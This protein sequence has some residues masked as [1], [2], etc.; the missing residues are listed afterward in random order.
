ML[1]LAPHRRRPSKCLAFLH[2]IPILAATLGAFSD[3]GVGTVTA[4]LGSP[5]GGSGVFTNSGGGSI[6]PY[7]GSSLSTVPYFAALPGGPNAS[8]P[9]TIVLSFDTPQSDLKLLWGS[10]DWPRAAYNL[11]QFFNTDHGL[12][13]SVS[14]VTLQ[15]I[16]NTI[17][18]PQGDPGPNGTRLV[19]ISGFDQQFSSVEFSAD[20][21]AFEFNLVAAPGPIPGAGLLSYIALGVLGLGSAAWRRYRHAV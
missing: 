2:R 11:V 8:S 15:G 1:L 20:A 10:I 19:D 18:G 16:D 9:G 21:V 14:G 13:G 4:T 7:N 6:A 12:I 5:A 3:P 17:P